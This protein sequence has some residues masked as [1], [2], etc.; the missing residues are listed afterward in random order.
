MNTLTFVRAGSTLLL[1]PLIPTFAPGLKHIAM[2]R[3]II[4]LCLLLI[5]QPAFATID[6]IPSG[7]M[8]PELLWKLGRVSA[9]GITADGKYVVY[10]VS[11][12][13]VEANRSTRKTY[14]VPVDGG[15]ATAISNPDSV[16]RNRFI[17]PD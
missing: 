11:T 16:L 15:T 1:S 2:L 10:T 14:M 13:D 6:S 5:V 4:P 7:R 3:S 9:Q 12:P 17:S 8:S